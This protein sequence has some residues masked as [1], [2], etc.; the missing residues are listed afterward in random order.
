[1]RILV[2]Q[3][4]DEVLIEATN[5]AVAERADQ[6]R[7]RLSEVL[8]EDPE[9]LFARHL[10]AASTAPPGSPGI[11]LVILRKDYRARLAAEIVPRDGGRFDITVQ[12]SLPP[13]EVD[14]V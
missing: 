14:P 7:A 8:A 13:D 9:A 5:T 3:L 1:V 11:G 12:V 4:G 6:F 10:E 2:A